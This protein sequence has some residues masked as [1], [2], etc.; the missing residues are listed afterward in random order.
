MKDDDKS[1]GRKFLHFTRLK[2]TDPIV[3]GIFG[4]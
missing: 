3:A 2:K 4:I 1:N